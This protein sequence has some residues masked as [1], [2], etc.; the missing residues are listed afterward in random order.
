MLFKR[1]ILGASSQHMQMLAVAGIG[2]LANILPVVSTQ[3]VDHTLTIA[4]MSGGALC[5]T[6][7][8]AGRTVTTPTGED[9]Q[10]AAPDMD[11]G[12]SFSFLVAVTTAFAAT[13]AA[14]VGVTLKGRAT[15]P[16]SET[17]TIVVVKTG[18]ETFDWYCL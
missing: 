3:N 16:A 2:M 9:I 12:D 18:D 1:P 6:S 14:G 7:F 10:A 15:V 4:Q 13:W 8:S 17:C 11:V 5:Y